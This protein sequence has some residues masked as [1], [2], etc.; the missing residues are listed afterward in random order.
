[1]QV[2]AGEQDEEVREEG[3]QAVAEAIL[4]LLG[5]LTAVG[6]LQGWE[7]PLTLPVQGVLGL[8]TAGTAARDIGNAQ[9]ELPGSKSGLSVTQPS[10]VEEVS[11][12]SGL[13]AS[14]GARPVFSGHRAGPRQH[15][16]GPDNTTST[17]EAVIKGF[18]QMLQICEVTSWS[19]LSKVGAI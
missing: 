6:Q 19:S 10:I 1:M 5:D 2:I 14:G 18:L 11:V 4:Q 13:G 7:M 9:N 8:A 15:T 17:S 16:A 3:K 12:E